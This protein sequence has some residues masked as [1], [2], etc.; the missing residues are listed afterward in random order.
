MT[1]TDNMHDLAKH[2]ESKQSYH[3]FEGMADP[4][5]IM[6]LCQIEPGKYVWD[7]SEHKDLARSLLLGHLYERADTFGIEDLTTDKVIDLYEL[8][9][10]LLTCRWWSKVTDEQVQDRE[11]E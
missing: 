8:V 6:A 11:G 2:F 7:R 10:N 5:P 1:I 3:D 9:E 4:K